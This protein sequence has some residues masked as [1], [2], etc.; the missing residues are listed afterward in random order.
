[1]C[2]YIIWSIILEATLVRE[3]SLK[4]LT[5]RR[6]L[7]LYLGTTLAT[8]Q[9]FG[10]VPSE[11][12]FA[13]IEHKNALVVSFVYFSIFELVLSVPKEVDNDSFM[14][15]AMPEDVIKHEFIPRQAREEAVNTLSVSSVVKTEVN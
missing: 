14:I 5:L 4:L 7:L 9:S 15:L 11:S 6:S 1:M 12:D 3:T 10:T 2:E 13:K 8:F